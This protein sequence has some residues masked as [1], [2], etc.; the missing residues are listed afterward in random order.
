MVSTVTHTHTPTV[1]L[2]LKSLLNSN[3]PSFKNRTKTRKT[4]KLCVFSKKYGLIDRI[5]SQGLLLPRQARY[6]LRYTRRQSFS[7]VVKH[8]VNADFLTVTGEGK[9]AVSLSAPRLPGF[10]EGC[11]S[12]LGLVLPNR[13][14]GVYLVFTLLKTTVANFNNSR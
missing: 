7:I 14:A 3:H 5:R 8:V 10:S 1:F 13:R 4:A 9:S 2:L 6:Q 11:G 12:N